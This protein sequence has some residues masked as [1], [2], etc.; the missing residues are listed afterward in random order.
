MTVDPAGFVLARIVEDE[1]RARARRP[2]WSSDDYE[3]LDRQERLFNE[4][5]HTSHCGYRMGEFSDPCV[6]GVPARVLA[7]CAA[8]RLIWVEHAVWVSRS[9]VWGGDPRYCVTCDRPGVPVRW[10]CPSMRA[11]A[12]PYAG[13]PDFRPEWKP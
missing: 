1:A 5:W 4:Q 7:E 11:L 12:L 8:K 10:P 6:C 9:S 13:H 2:D 3:D